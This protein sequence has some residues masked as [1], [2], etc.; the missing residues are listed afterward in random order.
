MADNDNESLRFVK[1]LQEFKLDSIKTLYHENKNTAGPT[2][3]RENQV[4]DKK[5]TTL[6][7]FI[8]SKRYN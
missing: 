6:M 8:W 1:Q 3:D 7:Q 2:G 5:N 4:C